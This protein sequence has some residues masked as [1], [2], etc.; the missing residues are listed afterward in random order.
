MNKWNNISNS[1]SQTCTCVLPP[2]YT[3][4]FCDMF[5]SNKIVEGM[6]NLYLI[7]K[8]F[9]KVIPKLY[10]PTRV[11]ESCFLFLEYWSL[12]KG[13]YQHIFMVLIF[14]FLVIYC[15]KYF[16]TYYIWKLSFMTCLF[17]S[18]VH[19]YIQLSMFFLH[20]IR[21]PCILLI[22]FCQLYASNNVSH[23]AAFSIGMYEQSQ[24]C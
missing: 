1:Q 18:L 10:T 6:N 8:I 17:K 24:L 19:F 13:V 15:V 9:S 23:T 7:L 5:L 14:I 22:I 11:N 12:L 21:I 2:K 3:Y 16:F 20:S 4:F